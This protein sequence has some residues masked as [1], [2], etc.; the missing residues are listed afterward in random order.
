VI[1]PI[2]DHAQVRGIW[3]RDSVGGH[4]VHARQQVRPKRFRETTFL[5][6]NIALVAYEGGSTIIGRGGPSSIE[7]RRITFFQCVSPGPKTSVKTCTN[8]VYKQRVRMVDQ[9]FLETVDIDWGDNFKE[10]RIFGNGLT[11]HRV[12]D[13]GHRWS[14]ERDSCFGPFGDSRGYTSIRVPEIITKIARPSP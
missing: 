12:V 7:N 5:D 10:G 1:I 13:F 3:L 6:F 2:R 8:R 14:R 9:E 4:T 11:S